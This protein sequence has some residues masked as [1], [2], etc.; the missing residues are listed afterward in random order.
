MFQFSMVVKIQLFEFGAYRS[1]Y[2]TVGM[3]EN[4]S[5]Q[6]K[7]KHKRRIGRPHLIYKDEMVF[8]LVYLFVRYTNPHF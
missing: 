5:I 3:D 4:R 8:C 6:R 1:D 2:F 7:S